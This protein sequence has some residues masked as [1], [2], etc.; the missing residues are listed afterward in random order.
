VSAILNSKVL[1]LNRSYLPVHITSLR[2]ALT[3]LYCE[4]ALAV[5]GEY[6]TFD[7]PAWLRLEPDG[8]AL[9]LVD[10][11]LRVPRVILLRGFDRVPRREVRFSRFNV[12]ARDRG[13]CQYCGRRFPRAELNLDHVFPRSRGGVSAVGRARDAVGCRSRL[14]V[15]GVLRGDR[16]R[17]ISTKP[18]D[19]NG[20][21]RHRS[22]RRSA[23]ESGLCVS[24]PLRLCVHSRAGPNAE[25]QRREGAERSLESHGEACRLE[26]ACCQGNPSPLNTIYENKQ[27]IRCS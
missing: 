14:R 2:R 20:A 1:V 16:A 5:D 13:Q 15:L 11:A 19:T 12:Y 18:V 21:S 9:G 4:V 8:D 3:L 25:T 24:A 26:H 22:P 23:R 10:R 6:R 7:F 27:A 17:R